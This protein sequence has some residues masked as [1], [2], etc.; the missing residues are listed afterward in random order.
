MAFLRSVCIVAAI[1][2]FLWSHVTEPSGGSVVSGLLTANQ[3]NALANS[4]KI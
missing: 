1:S 4:K 3:A 2:S